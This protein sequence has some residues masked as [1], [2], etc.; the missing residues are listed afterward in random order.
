MFNSNAGNPNMKFSYGAQP[1][2]YNTAPLNKPTQGQM[3]SGGMDSGKAAMLMSMMQGIGGQKSA[4]PTQT[5][6]PEYNGTSNLSPYETQRD[7]QS[8]AYQQAVMQAL[9]GGRV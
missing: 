6:G 1:S 2:N 8:I 9:M 4:D 7:P 5:F 3:G